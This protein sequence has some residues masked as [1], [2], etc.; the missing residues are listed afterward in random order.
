MPSADGSLIAVGMSDASVKVVAVN[1]YAT[2]AHVKEPAPPS[3]ARYLLGI[4]QQSFVSLNSS[5]SMPR[6]NLSLLAYFGGASQGIQLVNAH[7][8]ELVS[9][10]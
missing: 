4:A 3:S 7:T 6:P 9:Q 5:N 10:V 8:G 1:N 2:V